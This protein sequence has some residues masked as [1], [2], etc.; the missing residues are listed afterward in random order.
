MDMYIGTKLIN[1]VPM[2]RL[3]YNV[4]RGWELPADEDPTDE[5]YLVEY[6]DGGAANHPDYAGYISWSPKEVFEKS[7]RSTEG[8]SFGLAIE[9]AK[10]GKKIQRAGWNGKGM[11][12]ILVP[13]TPDCKFTEGSP[14]E[15]AGTV[16]ANIQPHFDLW[17]AQGEWQPGWLA[18]QSDM[19]ATDWRI[20]G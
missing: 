3:D 12:V 8:L 18:S 14:Y 5:G 4:L 13:G 2:N 16:Q 20:V 7:Y 19:L 1:A 9:A 17:T 11:F 15:V 10:A 6:L